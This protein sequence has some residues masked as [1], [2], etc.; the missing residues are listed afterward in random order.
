MVPS[1]PILIPASLIARAFRIMRA[2][3]WV[4]KGLGERKEEGNL[5]SRQN[6]WKTQG[7]LDQDDL[8]K[9]EGRI[10]GPH[11]APFRLLFFSL[12]SISFS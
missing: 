9:E 1:Y 11:G 3:F 6:T 10:A 8:K 2:D 5:W 12:E 7:H 4:E